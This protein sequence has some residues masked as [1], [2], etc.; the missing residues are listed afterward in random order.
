MIEQ[1]IKSAVSGKIIDVQNMEPEQLETLNESNLDCP[2]WV[3]LAAS[4]LG[5][6]DLNQLSFAD[7]EES[8]N[9]MED[10]VFIGN[11]EIDVTF[12]GYSYMK[13]GTVDGVPA[14]FL[15]DYGYNCFVIVTQ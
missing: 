11:E 5:A 6:T 13:K 2:T 10:I 1:F 8:Y 14:I 7:S 9:L 12:L 4:L 15:S 3:H